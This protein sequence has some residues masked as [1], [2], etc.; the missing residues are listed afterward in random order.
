[1]DVVEKPAATNCAAVCPFKVPA[2]LL[3]VFVKLFTPVNV[4]ALYVFA[5]DVEASAKY[6]AELVE[7]AM[8]LLFPSE[9]K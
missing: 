9:R 6:V 8:S 2:K 7:K 1:M 5:I 3:E 4:F